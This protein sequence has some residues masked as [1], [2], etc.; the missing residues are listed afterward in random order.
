MH[1]GHC[2]NLVK[3]FQSRVS[4]SHPILHRLQIPLISNGLLEMCLYLLQYSSMEIM[5]SVRKSFWVLGLKP[6]FLSF[7]YFISNYSK[8]LHQFWITAAIFPWT[9]LSFEKTVNIKIHT[10]IYSVCVCSCVF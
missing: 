1:V 6:L 8:K 2:N 3:R 10:A 7:L 5:S 4:L 9:A